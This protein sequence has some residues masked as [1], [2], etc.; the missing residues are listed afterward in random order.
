MGEFY[1]M[2]YSFGLSCFIMCLMLLYCMFNFS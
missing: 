1:L 2:F